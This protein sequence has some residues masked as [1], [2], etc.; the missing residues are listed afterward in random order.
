MCATGRPEIGTPGRSPYRLG[1]LGEQAPSLGES[2]EPAST[3]PSSGVRLPPSV[4]AGLCQ[5][6]LRRL[7]PSELLFGGV[8]LY[9]S[10]GS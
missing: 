8:Y 1:N 3:F 6:D 4:P 10:G 9:Q 2:V 7:L 5:V